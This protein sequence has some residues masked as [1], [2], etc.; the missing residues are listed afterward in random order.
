MVSSVSWQSKLSRSTHD[1]IPYIILNVI[2]IILLIFILIL[3]IVIIMAI[4]IVIII[5]I[6]ISCLL[7]PSGQSTELANLIKPEHSASGAMTKHETARR[8]TTT[9]TAGTI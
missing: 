7:G 8:S 5:V 2:L 1:C 3:I 9:A 4:I 6:S